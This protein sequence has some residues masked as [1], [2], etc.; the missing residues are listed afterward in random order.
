M[1]A[2]VAKQSKNFQLLMLAPPVR[3]QRGAWEAGR[4]H[5]QDN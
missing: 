4:G 3:K 2:V 1:L 5:S